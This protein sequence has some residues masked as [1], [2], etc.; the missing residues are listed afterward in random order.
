MMFD[1]KGERKSL[2]KSKYYFPKR[3]FDNKTL[4]KKFLQTN[5]YKK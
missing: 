5:K 3:Q 1:D 2:Q 4:L